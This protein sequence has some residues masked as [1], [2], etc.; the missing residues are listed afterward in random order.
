MQYLFLYLVLIL[1]GSRIWVITMARNSSTYHFLEITILF[2]FLS[3]LRHGR[4]R[5]DSRYCI[6]LLAYILCAIVFVRMMVGGVGVEVLLKWT[7]YVL[8]SWMAVTIDTNFF[9]ERFLIIT[10]ILAL[11]SISGFI[12]QIS[13]PG[14]LRG[15]LPEYA[16]NFSYSLW[17]N[18]YNGELFSYRAW[19]KYLFSFDEMHS[20]RNVGIFSEP[21]VY[22]IVLNSALFCLLFLQKYAKRI[23]GKRKIFFFLVYAIALLTCQSTTGYVGFLSII[24]TYLLASQNSNNKIKQRIIIASVIVLLGLMIEYSINGSDSLLY[25]AF[26]KK[27]FTGS[28]AISVTADS[29]I[30]RMRTLIVTIGLMIKNPLGVGY[31]KV[32]AMINAY[33]SDGVGGAGAVLFCTGAALGVLTMVAIIIWTLYPAFKSRILKMPEKILF[34]FLFFNTA[35][36]QSEEIY[37][38]IIVIPIFLYVINHKLEFSTSCGEGG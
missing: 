20:K 29:G 21:G 22:Q 37:A 31:D 25:R 3:C 16:S 12:L 17:G 8:I 24:L 15:I 9:I 6:T 28:G 26:I 5:H 11:I 13:M 38:T 2:L 4:V 19:G 32:N 36:A 27:L 7:T 35:L 14:V 34:A 30:Y 33:A 18:G 1:S 23:E 10:Y